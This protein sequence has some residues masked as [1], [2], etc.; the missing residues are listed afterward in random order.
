MMY[1][2]DANILMSA[3]DS[4][5]PIEVVP[6]F[7]RE[8]LELLD[9]NQARIHRSVY[10]E[11]VQYRQK[12]LYGWVKDNIHDAHILDL[13]KEQL[14]KLA[15]VTGWVQHERQP[16]YRQENL[17][18]FLSGAD[19]QIIA[20]AMSIEAVIVTYEKGTSNPKSRKVKIP[21][22]ASHFGVSCMSPIDMFMKCKRVL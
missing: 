22:V 19:P 21:D 15:L 9:S 14:I 16:P 5:Y 10:D 20:A 3:A 17:S 8:V 1:L 18:K 7:W 2:L 11:L 4:H 13:D 12:W 6:G